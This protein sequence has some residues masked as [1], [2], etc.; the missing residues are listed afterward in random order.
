M[1]ERVKNW[2]TRYNTLMLE[3][4]T[5]PFKWFD[6]DCVTFAAKALD[7]QYDIGM[8]AFIETNLKYDSEES[9]I[10]IIEAHQDLE[11]LVTEVLGIE[12]VPP[13]FLTVGDVVLY[14][15]GMP[16]FPRALAVH[17]GHQ[18]IAPAK[19]GLMYMHLVRSLKGWKP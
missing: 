12:T 17:D 6:H 7:A 4:A 5:R 18:L 11:N 1:V 14:D 16:G 13:A 2:R 19:S 10:A 3:S 8:M 15:Y 9:A